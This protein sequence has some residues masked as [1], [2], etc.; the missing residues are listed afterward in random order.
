MSYNQALM[1]DHIVSDINVCG[2][3]PCVKGT[4]IP[5]RIVLSH[6]AAGESHADIL[7]QFPNLKES[8]IRAC[9][10]YAAFL[11]SERAA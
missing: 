11:A 10:E 7:R 9:L 5:A 6:L 3:E 1:N 8:D 2:G 4:R